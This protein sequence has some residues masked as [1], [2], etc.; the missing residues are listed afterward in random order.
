MAVVGLKRGLTGGEREGREGGER[1]PVSPDNLSNPSSE[2]TYKSGTHTSHPELHSP[3]RTHY[4]KHTGARFH[5]H[6]W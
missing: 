2:I 6:W 1:L 5:C 3:Q 4:P